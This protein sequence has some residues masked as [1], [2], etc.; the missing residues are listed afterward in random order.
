MHN[1]FT[2]AT[3]FIYLTLQLT[4]THIVV[5]FSV[6]NSS[7]ATLQNF[8]FAYFLTYDPTYSFILM[9]FIILEQI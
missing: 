2:V 4:F 3:S 9:Q 7:F 5:D 8:D 1:A 6:L